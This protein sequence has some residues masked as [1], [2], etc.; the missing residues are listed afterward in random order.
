VKIFP[1]ILEGYIVFNSPGELRAT[2]IW[3]RGLQQ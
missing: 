2:V 1:N 3:R